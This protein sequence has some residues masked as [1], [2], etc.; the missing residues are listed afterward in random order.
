MRSPRRYGDAP[1]IRHIG[2]EL[3][4]DASYGRCPRRGVAMGTI[5]QHH[6]RIQPE[7]DE[8]YGSD[9]ECRGSDGPSVEKMGMEEM[10]GGEEA[11]EREWQS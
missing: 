2:D 10:E 6:R 9:R 8:A 7:D 3:A 4:D 1:R 11:D 5:N